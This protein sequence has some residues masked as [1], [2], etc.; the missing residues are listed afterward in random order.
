MEGSN[1]LGV[2]NL[3]AGHTHGRLTSASVTNAG[4]C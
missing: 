3:S 1:R 4:L 2:R